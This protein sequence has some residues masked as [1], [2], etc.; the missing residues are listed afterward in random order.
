MNDTNLDMERR[1][2]DAHNRI[3]DLTLFNDDFMSKV[4]EDLNCVEL[5]VRIILDRDDLKVIKSNIQFVIKNLQ[6]RSV[7]F[8]IFAVDGDKR[9]YDIEIQRSNEGASMKRARYNSSLIDA[10]MT[11]PGEKLEMLNESYV[12]FITENDVMGYGLPV[13]HIDRMIREVMAAFDDA[14]HI[15]YVNGQIRDETALGRLMHDFSCKSADDMYYSVLADRVRYFKEDVKGEE[16]MTDLWEESKREA[17]REAARE[18]AREVTREIAKNLLKMGKH[19]Y[20]EIASATKLTVD[21]VK[22]LDVKKTA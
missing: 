14:A 16:F 2:A 3:Q 6:G 4:F 15:I 19:S 8:D 22:A 11:E 10:N 1:R 21:E 17:A 20:E 13:Y 7:R 9:I 5:L 18:T 12:I